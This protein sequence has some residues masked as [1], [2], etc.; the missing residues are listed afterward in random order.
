MALNIDKLKGIFSIGQSVQNLHDND[1]II[2]EHGPCRSPCLGLQ[3]LPVSEDIYMLITSLWGQN[4]AYGKFP[5]TY[6]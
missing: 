6:R 3:N 4:W 1:G 2:F 5:E